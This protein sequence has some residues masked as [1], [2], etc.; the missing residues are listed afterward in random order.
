[1]KATK[2]NMVKQAIGV[3]NMKIMKKMKKYRMKVSLINVLIIDKIKTPE[4]RRLIAD[5]ACQGLYLDVRPNGRSYRYRFTDKRG[6][7][8][9]V[10]IGCAQ[11]LKLS[12]ARDRTIELKR[13]R[14]LGIGIA[15]VEKTNY[16]FT[17]TSLWKH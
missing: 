17:Y 1:M 12:D 9:S 11:A 3:G 16:L 7:H 5:G 4:K 15:A 8:R 14:A 10:T 13:E 6:I 2:Q